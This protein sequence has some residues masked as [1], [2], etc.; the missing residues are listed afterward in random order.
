MQSVFEI[1]MF[2]TLVLW[3]KYV[4]KSQGG[5]DYKAEQDYVHKNTD[6]V[7]N[8]QVVKGGSAQFNKI[9]TNGESS[10]SGNTTG[11]ALEGAGFT[12]YMLSE[13]SLIK[14]GTI[15]PAYGEVDGHE[16]VEA[17]HLVKLFDAAGNMLGYE[18]TKGYLK[19]ADLYT[20]FD[21]KYPD[22]YNLEDV[23]RLIYVR[24][25]GYYYEE[26]ILAAYRND[27]YDN[28]TKKLDF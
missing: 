12:V 11:E 18:F 16:L 3:Y 23:N 9:T 2:T 24:D 20:Y 4:D 10:S 1:F 26:D 21:E 15:A 6:Q 27:F 7:S 13:L 8:Q 5:K 14:D 17:D 22:G 28:D 25:R 19:D